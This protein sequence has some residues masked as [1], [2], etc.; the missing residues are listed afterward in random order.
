MTPRERL[1]TTLS[2]QEP[3][4]APINFHCGDAALRKMIESAD[5]APEVKQRFVHGDVDILTFRGRKNDPVFSPYH[6]GT[7]GEATI[8]DWGVGSLRHKASGTYLL[9]Q[10][11]YRNYSPCFS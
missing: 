4:R 2:H 8:D 3:D 1:L 9:T 10:Y 7:P 11:I 6:R 5:I